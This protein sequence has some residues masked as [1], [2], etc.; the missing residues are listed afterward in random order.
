MTIDSS[1]YARMLLFVCVLAVLI[2]VSYHRLLMA[3]GKIAAD[4]IL[5]YD[6]ELDEFAKSAYAKFDESHD[7]NH[8]KTVL[9][10][11]LAMVIPMCIR[12]RVVVRFDDLVIIVYAAL[13]HDTYDHKYNGIGLGR[14]RV[15]DW[16]NRKLGKRA[17]ACICIIDNMSWSKRKMATPIA[18]DYLRVLVQSADWIEA[19]G[20]TGLQRCIMYTKVMKSLDGESCRLEV[21]NHID[22]KLL[23]IPAELPS[24][25]AEFVHSRKLL[26]PLIEY[27]NA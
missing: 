14:D 8:A 5:R 21:I 11:A 20:A 7:Y 10:N 17:T 22:E 15:V 13:L 24:Y 18:R 1:S 12:E 3:V 16:V 23:K 2:Y 26:Q 27:K 25:A 6:Q 19:L 9:A 4:L